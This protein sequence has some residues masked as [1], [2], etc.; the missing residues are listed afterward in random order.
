MKKTDQKEIEVIA[1]TLI[2]LLGLAVVFGMW[3][4]A[5]WVV[6]WAFSVPFTVK[7]VFGAMGYFYYRKNGDK[8]IFAVEGPVLCWAWD[9]DWDEKI[10]VIYRKYESEAAFPFVTDQGF[11]KHCSPIKPEECFDPQE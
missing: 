2:V 6:C 10:P 7:Y 11:F 4:G 9:D 5:V 3:Y 1:Y 8:M